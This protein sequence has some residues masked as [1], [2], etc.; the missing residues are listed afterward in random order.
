[1]VPRNVEDAAIVDRSR[2]P[3]VRVVIGEPFRLAAVRSNPPQIHLPSALNAPCKVDP[4]AIRRPCLMMVVPSDNWIDKNLFG[5]ETGAIAA[6]IPPPPWPSNFCLDA[7]IASRRC[8]Y[9]AML[10]I[11]TFSSNSTFVRRIVS[12]YRIGTSSHPA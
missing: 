8:G 2:E 11:R 7:S 9:E 3:H 12:A 1:M 4:A 10:W 5:A 6:L